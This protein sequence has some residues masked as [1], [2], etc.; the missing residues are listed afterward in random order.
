MGRSVVVRL[1]FLDRLPFVIVS[2][3][4]SVDVLVCDV[5]EVPVLSKCV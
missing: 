1:S 5:Y 2:F 4:S 3:R